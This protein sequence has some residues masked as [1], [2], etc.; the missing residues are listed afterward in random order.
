MIRIAFFLGLFFVCIQGSLISEEPLKIILLTV[1]KSGTHL[2]YKAIH[3][4]TGR[5]AFGPGNK[6]R[7]HHVIQDIRDNKHDFYIDHL[8]RDY[9]E[10]LNA[11]S[12]QVRVVVGIR[13]PRDTIMS[14]VGW[15]EEGFNWWMS[16]AQMQAF[17]QLPLQ[18]R[19][20]ELILM[21]DDYYGVRKFIE[22]A[23]V[24]AQKSQAIVCYFEDFVGPQGGGSRYKQEKAIQDLAN[25][26][27][28]A[29]TQ[30]RICEIADQLYGGTN[31][32]RIGQIGRWKQY[33]NEEH[34]NLMKQVM[35]KEL[36]FL[37]YESDLDW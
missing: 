7:R 19:I 23:I 18:E 36:V 2:F 25:Y 15:V 10:W 4:I 21:P 16:R 35:G 22:H 37:G 8:Y 6:V 33:F 32:F 11:P 27:G 17:N 31:T 24:Y 9:F 20:K 28:Y 5:E 29:L 1:P 12:N 30:Q 13:D 3:L 14:I 34:I 26:L